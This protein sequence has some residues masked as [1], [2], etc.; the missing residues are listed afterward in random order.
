MGLACFFQAWGIATFIIIRLAGAG[1]SNL[2]G[3]NSNAERRL[4]PCLS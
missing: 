3:N 1:N 2:G 4:E